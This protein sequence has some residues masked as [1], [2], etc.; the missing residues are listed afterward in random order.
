MK[1]DITTVVHKG[2]STWKRN[3]AICVPFILEILSTVFLVLVSLVL[4]ASFFIL[5]AATT[6]SLNP[7]QLTPDEFMAITE[8]LLT[9]SFWSLL[10]FGIVFVL[11]YILIQSFF[12]AGAI[13]MSKEASERG[14]TS[15]RDMYEYGMKNLVNMFLTRILVL[16]ISLA[17]IVFMIPGILSIGDLGVLIDNPQQAIAGTFMLIFGLLLWFFYLLVVSI[18]LIFV[19]YAL[20][21]DGLDPVSAIEKGVSVFLSNKSST[22]GLWLFLMAIAVMSGLIGELAGYVEALSQIWSLTNFMLTLLVIQPLTI[23]WWTR[24]YLNRS[25]RKLYSIEDYILDH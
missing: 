10:A 15:I 3:L 9:G 17:G 8:S 24:L 2:F 13:G 20:V 23:I 4:F 19:Q 12:L 22:I 18:A 11:L 7:E 14:D 1:E 21:L 6:G 5:P 16:L 25:G